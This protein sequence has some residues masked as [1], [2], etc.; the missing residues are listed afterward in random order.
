MIDPYVYPDTQTLINQYNI[1]DQAALQDIESAV[2]AKAINTPFPKGQWNYEHLKAIHHHFFGELYSWAGSERTIDIS[3]NDSLFCLSSFIHKE[4]NKLFTQLSKEQHLQGLEKSDFCERMAHYFN[5][6]NAVHPFREG[7]GRTLRAFSSELAKQAGFELH[8]DKVDR[9]TYLQAS[10]DGFKGISESMARIFS[11]I[12]EP[13]FPALIHEEKTII[14]LSDDFKKIAPIQET[15]TLQQK[16]LNYAAM[17][18]RQQELVWAHYETRD[19]DD[20]NKTIEAKE[21]VSAH[22]G[23]LNK[24]SVELYNDPDVQTLIKALHHIAL[25][26]EPISWD[27]IQK[28]LMTFPENRE[29]IKP[30]LEPIKRAGFQAK[31]A[32]SQKQSQHQ[33]GGRK[34]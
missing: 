26:N 15:P 8:W 23:E 31:E 34:R 17:Q 9:Q 33:G 27:N 29:A 22:F 3:K 10:I 18:K 30:L 24:K 21:I 28:N 14:T 12:S 11:I 6:L 1:R 16:L 13:L 19:G 2:Y 32:L 7:N 4:I 20:R 25:P 5:E